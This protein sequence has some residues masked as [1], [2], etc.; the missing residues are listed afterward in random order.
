MQQQKGSNLITYQSSKRLEIARKTGATRIKR[1]KN[2]LARSLIFY[3]SHF[4]LNLH[5]RR[6]NSGRAYECA[7]IYLYPQEDQ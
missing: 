5:K 1:I 7:G 2:S 3:Q 4:S 6:G